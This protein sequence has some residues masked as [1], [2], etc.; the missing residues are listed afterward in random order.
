[1]VRPT[2]TES[3]Q[4]RAS[5]PHGV[6]RLRRPAA[7]AQLRSRLRRS[8]SWRGWG[9]ERF[10]PSTG[11]RASPVSTQPARCEPVRGLP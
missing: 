10:V 7:G 8:A 11:R 6:G 1:V 2:R 9:P 4:R 5:P 3:P